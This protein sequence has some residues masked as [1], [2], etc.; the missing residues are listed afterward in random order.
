MESTP[1]A[2]PHH[3]ALL[4]RQALTLQMSPTPAVGTSIV[5]ENRNLLNIPIEVPES[6]LGPWIGCDPG[7]APSRRRR[8]EHLSG[9]RKSVSETRPASLESGYSNRGSLGRSANGQLNLPDFAKGLL[10]RGEALG[11]NKTFMNAVSEIKVRLARLFDAAT[12]N[13]HG[14]EIFLIL[15]RTS[16]ECH[17]HMGQHMPRIHSWMNVHQKHVRRGSPARASKWNA[18][19]LN[20][21]PY[22]AR[23]VLLS[24]GS[25]I[26]CYSTKM[27]TSQK[28]AL[29]K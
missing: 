28:S 1:S 6:P 27:V 3:T 8:G 11:I 21:A 7:P 20:Y 29:K 2:A 15:R 12:D 22:S 19:P 23:L 25:W 26:R 17:Q 24:V 10:D 13:C 5:F 4:V 18:M 9:R 16:Y 14:R